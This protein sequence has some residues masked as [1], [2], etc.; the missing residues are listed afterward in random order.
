MFTGLSDFG[1]GGRMTLFDM[2]TVTLKSFNNLRVHLQ[3]VNTLY[4]QLTIQAVCT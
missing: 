3:M 2:C 1:M 4:V